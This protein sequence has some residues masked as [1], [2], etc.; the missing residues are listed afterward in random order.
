MGSNT[1][2]IRHLTCLLLTS[3]AFACATESEVESPG[4]AVR[5]GGILPGGG[6]EPDPRDE[7]CDPS[8]QVVVFNAPNVCDDLMGGTWLGQRIFSGGGAPVP[9]GLAGYCRY[10]FSGSSSPA[11]VE[12]LT[13]SLTASVGANAYE[14]GTDCRSV[15]PQSSAIS[16]EVGDE[17]DSYFGWLSGR[18]TPEQIATATLLAPAEIHTAIVDT[19]PSDPDLDPGE[20]PHST[21]G[22]VVAS[23]VESF[24]CPTGVGCT[25]QVRNY[26]GLP[27]TDE[28]IDLERGGQVGLQ[29][30]LAR[31]IY[32]ALVADQQMGSERLVINLSVAWE[33]EEFGGMGLN[34]MAPAVRAVYDVLRTARCRGALIIAAAGNQSG[35]SCAG[36]PM[37]PAR[38]EDIPAPD[39]AECGQLGITNAFVD[40]AS[41]APLVHAIGGLRGP[42]TEMLTSRANGM[43][44]L[45]A[46]SSHAVA[47]PREGLPD[48]AVRT[49]TSVATAVASAA[50]SLVWSYDTS[51]SPST[52][53]EK[54]YLSGQPVGTL[55]SDFGPGGPSAV[56]RVDACAA[57]N[58]T[59]PTAPLDCEETPP[60]TVAQIVTEVEAAVSETHAVSTDPG[61]ECT[62]VCDNEYWFYPVAGSARDCTQVEPDPWRWLTAPQPTEAGC[63]ECIL[64]TESSM[65]EAS[66]ML[67]V[68]DQFD[69][70]EIKAVELELWDANKEKKIFGISDKD[71]VLGAT[72]PVT[73][74]IGDYVVPMSLG[75]FE[76]VEA[77]IVMSFIDEKVDE[78][79]ETRDAMFLKIGR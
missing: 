32:H 48:I 35:L 59:I 52:V 18:V 14:I 19:Y 67:T 20:L 17:L 50:A 33:A 71:L 49:G 60:V 29:S 27:R 72:S 34:D 63:D 28:G 73:G 43:P 6:A 1:P 41:F 70:Y 4:T 46:A 69:G 56:H 77:Y 22:P 13:A 36:E 57:V 40:P 7:V 16:D 24:L 11:D 38:W 51:L 45:A 3:T 54:L 21:H 64:T 61:V 42:S 8:N 78:S 30:D 12:G 15:Q 55:T 75:G 53:M 2:F 58:L 26:L 62:D 47:Q 10:T 65:N 5:D 31:G 9:T 23:I 76:P 79:I 44:R 25:H 68:G 74:T 66:A 37:A 39:S